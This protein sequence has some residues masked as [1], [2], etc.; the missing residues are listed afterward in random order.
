MNGPV[1]KSAGGEIKGNSNICIT[2]QNIGFIIQNGY[3]KRCMKEGDRAN[4]KIRRT[5]ALIIGNE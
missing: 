3:R 1:R 2:G 5:D 4:G